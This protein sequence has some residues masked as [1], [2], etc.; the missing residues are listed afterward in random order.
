MTQKINLF[1][2]IGKTIAGIAIGNTNETCIIAFDDDTFA[3]IDATGGGESCYHEI[4]LDNEFE[5]LDFGDSRL[6]EL[7]LYS[8]D[9]IKAI[10]AERDAK[11]AALREEGERTQLQRLLQKYG[12]PQT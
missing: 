2:A 11:W 3:T 12:T 10:R 7:G 5:P 1:D 9:G 4:S 8:T 6:V